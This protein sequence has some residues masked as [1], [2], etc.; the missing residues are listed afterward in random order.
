[1]NKNNCLANL[2]YPHLAPCQHPAD[3]VKI[4]LTGE[5]L[6]S[7]HRMEAESDRET[8]ETIIKDMKDVSHSIHQIPGHFTMI[9]FV[10]SKRD[11]SADILFETVFEEA[12]EIISVYAV[13]TDN[14]ENKVY[15]S[16][17]GY[18][19]ISELLRFIVRWQNEQ[20]KEILT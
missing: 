12:P 5:Q 10:S 2:P 1:M 18:D 7:I 19:R 13:L 15:L 6:C 3:T 9:S 11:Y 8:W 14:Y 16:A 4:S 20:R 17:Q